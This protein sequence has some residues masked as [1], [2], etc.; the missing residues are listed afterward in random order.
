MGTHMEPHME[1][2]NE[3]VNEK[4]K[5]KGVQGGKEKKGFTPPTLEQV[6]AYFAERKTSLNPVAFHAHYEANGWVQGNAKKPIKNWKACVTTWEEKQK[7]FTLQAPVQAA[8]KPQAEV[9][10]LQC[11]ALKMDDWAIKVHML[12]KGYTEHRIDEA[13][14]RARGNVK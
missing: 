2:G 14:M 3:N 6:Q 10:A 5:D 8:G 9:V 1:T 11:V 12:E 7:E 13:L 4:I